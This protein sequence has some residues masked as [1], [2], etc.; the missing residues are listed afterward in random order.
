MFLLYNTNN[1]YEHK[2]TN[3]HPKSISIILFSNKLYSLEIVY[4]LFFWGHEGCSGDLKGCSPS[5]LVA[6][7]CDPY[8][9]S[10]YYCFHPGTLSSGVIWLLTTYTHLCST[11]QIFIGLKTWASIIAWFWQTHN[12][13]RIFSCRI[14]LKFDLYPI[15][16]GQ[17]IVDS[18]VNP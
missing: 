3:T 15:A 8:L 5:S 6:T 4:S 11:K 2:N 1:E 10:Y 18:H 17:T 13:R 16:N 9:Y 12:I 7:H 14:V